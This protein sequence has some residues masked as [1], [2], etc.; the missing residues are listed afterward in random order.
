MRLQEG[1][2]FV[3]YSIAGR[4]TDTFNLMFVWFNGFPPISF[5]LDEALH[6][7]A[8][9]LALRHSDRRVAALLLP[10]LSAVLLQEV[11]EVPWHVMFLKMKLKIHPLKLTVT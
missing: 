5:A 3:G 8:A 2:S 1:I 10:K 7:T 6:L 4:D 11:V 9:S